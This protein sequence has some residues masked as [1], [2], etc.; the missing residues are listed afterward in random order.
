L[1]PVCRVSI[2]LDANHCDSQMI[3]MTLPVFVVA[4]TGIKTAAPINVTRAAAQGSRMKVGQR[5]SAPSS[6]LAPNRDVI[7]T[8]AFRRV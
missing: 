2:D 8:T 6:E 3:A 5:C 7:F 4:Q 1:R